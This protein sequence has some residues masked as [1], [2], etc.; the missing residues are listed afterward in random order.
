MKLR[1]TIWN[2]RKRMRSLATRWVPGVFTWSQIGSLADVPGAWPARVVLPNA[3]VYE[4]TAEEHDLFR[5]G[6]RKPVYAGRSLVFE[7]IAVNEIADGILFPHSG[8][9][10][11]A[12]GAL[13][14]ESS[15]GVGQH[16]MAGELGMLRWPPPVCF[17]ETR[18]CTSILLSGQ[19]ANWYH[20]FIDCLPRLYALSRLDE[21]IVLLTSSKLPPAFKELLN[22]VCPPNVQPREIEDPRPLRCR[23][24]LLSPSVGLSGCGLVR[25]EIAAWLRDRLLP[26]LPLP[27]G[28]RVFATRESAS[29]RKLLTEDAVW[30]L[31]EARGF[32]KVAPGALSL[33]DQLATFARASVVV[34]PH[35][36]NL[37]NLIVSTRPKVVELHPFNMCYWGL[38]KV[39]GG[40]YQAVFGELVGETFPRVHHDVRIEPAALTAALDRLGL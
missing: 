7:P 12:R 39:A 24:L 13:L 18:P 30:T 25:S 37:T 3:E 27:A 28:E 16:L 29:V 2:A 10:A 22:W 40:E 36:A 31:L 4:P 26:R 1:S 23:R 33:A 38:T 8:M 21:E 14:V 32:R 34:G 15:K 5:R 9:M 17:N 6:F 20:Y 35:G 19:S 11:S